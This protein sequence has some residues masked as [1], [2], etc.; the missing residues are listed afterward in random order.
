MNEVQR[1]RA[2][3]TTEL[4]LASVILLTFQDDLTV[5]VRS[6]YALWPNDNHQPRALADSLRLLGITAIRVRRF[7]RRLG[8]LVS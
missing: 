4:L 8:M 7:L 6:S 5:S 2:G 3:F 1:L